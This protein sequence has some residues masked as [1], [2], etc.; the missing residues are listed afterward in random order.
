MKL[1]PSL[2]GRSHIR[3]SNKIFFI[4]F[5]RLWSC[6]SIRIVFE[7]S[8][9][10]TVYVGS[11]AEVVVRLCTRFA[12]TVLCATHLWRASCAVAERRFFHGCGGREFECPTRHTRA[13]A[14]SPDAASCVRGR[15]VLRPAP[16]RHPPA[17]VALLLTARRKRARSTQPEET[18]WPDQDPVFTVAPPEAS[19]H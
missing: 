14:Q 9:S 6:L 2:L 18:T 10:I 1:V 7:M 8:C 12:P 15:P 5:P 13:H 16:A 11:W 4:H 17:P 19:G 3:T